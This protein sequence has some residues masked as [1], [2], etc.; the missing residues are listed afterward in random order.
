MKKYS[1]SQYSYIYPSC[2]I[3]QFTEIVNECHKM[4]V[5]RIVNVAVTAIILRSSCYVDRAIRLLN[6]KRIA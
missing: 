5:M 4:S 2:D 1:K 6:V 3:E